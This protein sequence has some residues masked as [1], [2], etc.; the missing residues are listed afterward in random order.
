MST[1]SLDKSMEQVAGSEQLQAK[2]GEE[3]DGDALI[4]LGAKHGFEFSAED[5]ESAA[6]LSDGDLD[7]I[8]GGPHYSNWRGLKFRLRVRGQDKTRTLT[9]SSSGWRWDDSNC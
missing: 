1:A 8:A 7:G 4:A 3:I 9:F 2:I 5:L 6:K